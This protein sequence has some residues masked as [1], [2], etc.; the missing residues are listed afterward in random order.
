MI[1]VKKQAVAD[2]TTIFVEQC[3]HTQFCFQPV[4]LEKTFAGGINLSN[5]RNRDKKY[6][7]PVISQANPCLTFEIELNVHGSFSTCF[8]NG[9]P[10]AW[11][12][13]AWRRR[14]WYEMAEVQK[15]EGRRAGGGPAGR[16]R[17]AGLCPRGPGL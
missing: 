7:F 4:K 12:P 10:T 1:F 6:A 16:G 8:V 15:A 13:T 3:S 17:E 11:T 2:F 9:T 14:T 5:K